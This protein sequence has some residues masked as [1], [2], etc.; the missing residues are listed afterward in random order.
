[1]FGPARRKWCLE[2]LS[3]GVEVGNFNWGKESPQG[4]KFLKL[5]KAMI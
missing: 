5:D 2:S 1:M 3:R 4:K